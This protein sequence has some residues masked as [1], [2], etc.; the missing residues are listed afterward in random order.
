V[1]GSWV[2]DSGQVSKR[3]LPLLCSTAELFSSA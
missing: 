2:D 3:V 1:K